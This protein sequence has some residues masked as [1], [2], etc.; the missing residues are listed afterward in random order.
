MFCAVASLLRAFFVFANK[1]FVFFCF[2][3]A[4]VG[5]YDM[6]A[7][8]QRALICR[9]VPKLMQFIAFLYYNAKVFVEAFILVCPF[10][11]TKD[12]RLL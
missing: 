3:G 1:F 11:P 8:Y 5:L 9:S 7:L 12:T 2:F 4:Q 6:T 10:Y